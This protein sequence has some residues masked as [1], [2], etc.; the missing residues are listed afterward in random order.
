MADSRSCSQSQWCSGSR[1]ATPPALSLPI[2]QP[3]TTPFFW[4]SLL[5]APHPQE[6]LPEC[7]LPHS[8]FIHSQGL[9]SWTREAKHL[10][11]P[12]TLSPKAHRQVQELGTLRHPAPRTG[13]CAEVRTGPSP[14]GGRRGWLA[15]RN[16]P[17]AS[18][19]PC[20]CGHRQ[21]LRSQPRWPGHT[22]V[23]SKTV[24]VL[25]GRRIPNCK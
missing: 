21:A 17:G 8:P 24:Y 6:A 20:T 11:E 7:P 19:F 2:L 18:E 3:E 13:T 25:T 23:N 5:P 9:Q 10:A 1:L 14:L 16:H 22:A 12:L 4:D 15:L